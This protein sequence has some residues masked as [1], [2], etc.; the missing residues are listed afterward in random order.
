MPAL[1]RNFSTNYGTFT[2][3]LCP[4]V[5][6]SLSFCLVL[7]VRLMGKIGSRTL[8]QK[9]VSETCISFLSMCYAFLCK[10]FSHTSLLHRIEHRFHKSFSTQKMPVNTRTFSRPPKWD[11]YSILM[12]IFSVNCC[13]VVRGRLSS[14]ATI[15]C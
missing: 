2:A 13:S 15:M 7:C 8:Y 4:S 9:I 10:F 6:L 3:L 5:F 1:A 12:S 14:L 11:I